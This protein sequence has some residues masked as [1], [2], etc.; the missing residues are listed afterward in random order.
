MTNTKSQKPIPPDNRRQVFHGRR[1]GRKLRPRMADNLKRGLDLFAIPETVVESASLVNPQDFFDTP[2]SRFFLEIGFGGGEHLAA[3]AAA[4]P[5][6][7]FIGAEPFING[8]ASLCRHI[9][10]DNLANIRIWPEDVRLLLPK[11]PD[12]CFAGA[13]I[14][15]PDPW[16]KA[17]HAN[18]RILQPMMLTELGR[19]IA[20]GGEILL[21]SDDEVAKSWILRQMLSNSA[22]EWQAMSPKDWRT[23]PSCG[24][25]LASK[26]TRYMAKAEK[27]NRIPNWFLYK[28]L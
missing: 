4:N 7:G 23:P 11:L 13:F 22:F 15:F 27:S 6:A 12:K 24:L 19:L 17:R 10:A 2:K 5:D 9:F 26:T 14:L 21:A 28:R 8:V 3:Q 20:S 25:S 1:H 16:P 18:R